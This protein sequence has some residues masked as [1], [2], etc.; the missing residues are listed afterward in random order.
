[1]K[2]RFIVAIAFVL[3]LS[4]CGAKLVN[5]EYGY[6]L[7]REDFSGCDDAEEE[8]YVSG[9]YYYYFPCLESQHYYIRDEEGNKYTVY[10]IL[11]EELLTIEQVY[12]LFDGHIHRYENEDVITSIEQCEVAI[13]E[14][15]LDVG[16]I[17]GYTIKR[18][19]WACEMVLGSVV[20]DG[21]DFGYIHSGC[22]WTIDNVGYY[23]EKDG[24]TYDLS[25]LVD[26][27]EMTVG[28]IHELYMC[29]YGRIGL[30][31]EITYE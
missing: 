14:E 24:V 4:G 15:E 6:K 9:E 22:D 8:V 30:T 17:N 29:D 27:G 26:S 3:L 18:Q 2:L 19:L 13:P 5:K 23:A 21:Y 10:E 20:I 7:F 31:I 28:Q 16:E 25:E 12:N 11:E 1:M